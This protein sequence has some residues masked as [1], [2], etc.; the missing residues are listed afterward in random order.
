MTPTWTLLIAVHAICAIYALF[1]GAIQLLRRKGD[2]PHRILGRIWISTMAVALVTSFGILTISGTF[3]V[4]HALSLFTASTIT[5]G[6]IQAR[7]GRIRSH[8]AFM[9]GSYLGLLGAFVG[10]L[11]VPTRRIPELAV[12]EPWLL[13]LFVA[14]VVA[15]TAMTVV[16]VVRFRT[17]TADKSHRRRPI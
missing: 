7:R 16:G 17:E 13:A 5:I 14:V 15:S 10:V 6:V 11:A 12:H 8:R 2:R 1:F 9:I 4:L 3:G